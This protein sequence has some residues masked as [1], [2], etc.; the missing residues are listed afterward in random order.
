M[1]NAGQ[2]GMG[3]LGLGGLGLGGGLGFGGG[4]ALNLGAGGGIAGVGG[5][6]GGAGLP[7]NLAQLGGQQG[8]MGGWNRYQPGWGQV[9]FQGGLAAGLQATKPADKE[10][11]G[12]RPPPGGKLTYEQMQERIRQQQAEREKAKKIGSHLTAVDP[13]AGV[14]ALASGEEIG[15]QFQYVIDQKVSLP[16]QK[17]ALLPIVNEAAEVTPVSIYNEK[18]D[19]R[20]PVLGLK[21][22][23]TSGHP[24][25]QGPITVYER[26][27]YAGDAQLPDLQPKEERLIGYAVD[28][29][30]EV[31]PE[32]KALPEQLVAVKVAKGI[33]HTTNKLRLSKTYLIR[34]RSPHNRTLLL[35]HPVKPDWKLVAPE[36]PAEQ[37]RDVYRFSLAVAAGKT[38]RLEVIEERTRLGRVALDSTDEQQIR[39]VVRSSVITPQLREALQKALNLRAVLAGTQQELLSRQ[40]ELKDMTDDQARL[41]A[42]L[43]A[44]PASSAAYKRFL[45]KFDNQEGLIEKLQA[46]IK[47]LQATAKQQQKEYEDYLAGLNLE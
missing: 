29:G 12:E 7:A 3:G 1:T 26:G 5:G 31:K 47:Q 25:V 43:S 9:G 36:K 46:D 23:N 38:A 16:R 8:Q 30:T 37:S 34:N 20:F 45:E 24:L 39:L 4:P 40:S 21:F 17:S 15:D 19:A 44:L 33:L 42:N 14:T 41:R 22:K 18:V 35:E 6:L 28:L 32:A 2:V 13:S 11:E 10:E 27:S